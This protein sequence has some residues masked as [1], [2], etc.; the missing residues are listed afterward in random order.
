MY[1]W[2]E[3]REIINSGKRIHDSDGRNEVEK[4]RIEIEVMVPTL[5]FISYAYSSNILYRAVV[6]EGRARG[7]GVKKKER[8][9]KKVNKQQKK[10]GSRLH[11]GEGMEPPGAAFVMPQ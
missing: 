2:K 11:D 10:V 9:K 1:R 6:D 7:K 5:R 8:N 4:K 3:E